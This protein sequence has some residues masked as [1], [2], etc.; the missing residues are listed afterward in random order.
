[1]FSVCLLPGIALR[2]AEPPPGF[3]ALFNGRDLTGWRGGASY[4]YRKFMDLP[5]TERA[6]LVAGWTKSFTDTNEKTGKPHWRVEGGEVINVGL[7]GYAT[8]ERD[9]GDFELLVDYKTVPLADSGIYLRGVPQVQIWD[10]GHPNP[11]GRAYAK[12]S[13]GL[14]N[15]SPESPG[16]DPLVVADKP[17]GEWNT[18]RILMVGAH[19]T[20]WLNDKLVVDHVELENV[21]DRKLPPEQ[22]RP[23]PARGPVQL[24][25]HGGEIRW[26]NLFIREIGAEEAARV[27]ARNAPPSDVIVPKAPIVLFNGRDLSNFYSW[28]STSGFA[29]PTSVAM[30]VQKVDGA[31]AIR[32]SGQ[33]FGGIITKE[34]YAN[35]RLVAEFRWGLLTWE[36]RKDIAR[37]SG[38]LLHC[39]GREGN[40]RDNFRAAWMRSVEFQIIEGGTGDMLLV[41]GH[42]R[43]NGPRIP[44][45]MTCSTRQVPSPTKAGAVIERWDPTAPAKPRASRVYVMKDLEKPVGEWNRL[46]AIA[47]GDSV[48]FF[49]NGTQVN[50]GTGS[51]L[52]EGKLLFQSEGAEIF[53]RRIE[54][55]PLSRTSSASASSDALRRE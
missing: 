24:Q 10:K 38:I 52:R 40:Y 54:L 28:M 39:Q 34:R 48:T 22:R 3:A 21:F 50:G 7:G 41:G 27:L 20:V 1:L 23:V 47:D 14:Y 25:T 32:M 44:T 43:A 2:A 35:Y 4:D 33:F 53:F 8:T 45:T 12:G 37:D 30:V 49:V 46:E 51:S 17:L 29:D 15:N 9:Y 16:K 55:H 36:P 5:G 26:R 18:F 13:G 31:P 42:D 19:V 11:K 6:A